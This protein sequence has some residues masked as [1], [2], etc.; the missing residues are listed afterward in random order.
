MMAVEALQSRER[1]HW[2]AKQGRVIK[3]Y[4]FTHCNSSLNLK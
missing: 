4:Y 3:S 1:V 2:E